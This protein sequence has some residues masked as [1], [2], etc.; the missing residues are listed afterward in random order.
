MVNGYMLNLLPVIVG[1]LG[2][3]GSATS[4]FPGYL[5]IYP[6]ARFRI[7]STTGASAVLTDVCDAHL[8]QKPGGR[9]TAAALKTKP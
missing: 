7:A 8:A 5:R 4:G 1:G 6:Y 3:D 2:V 9:A